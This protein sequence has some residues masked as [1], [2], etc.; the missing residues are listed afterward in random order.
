MATPFQ[1]FGTSATAPFTLKIHRG[2]GMVLLAMDWK[3]G[4][5]PDDFVGFAI[6]Y[7]PPGENQFFVLSNRLSF[8]D[9][10][11]LASGAVRPKRFQSTVSPIQKFRWVHFP[12]RPSRIGPFTY[13]VTPMSMQPDGHL[14]KGD[15]QTAAITLGDE[16]YPGQINIAFTRGFV[17]SQ[18]FV[19]RYLDRGSIATLVPDRA[20]DG[21]TFQPTH[22]DAA[23]AREW[24]G[25]EARTAILSVLDEAIA[26]RAAQVGV[27]AYDLNQPEMLTRLEALGPRL[28]III[29]DSNPHGDAHS[30]ETQAAARLAVSAGAGNVKRQHMGNLQHNKMIVV[31]GPAA[32]KAVGG[33]TNF[34]WRG[35]FIQSNNAVVVTGAAA[36]APF[37][38]AFEAY[39]SSQRTFRREPPTQIASLGLAGIDASVTFSPHR[40]D[41]ARLPQMA[42]EIN[43][44]QS[45]LFY[46]LAFLSQT[47]GAVTKAIE[48]ATQRSDLFIY[49]MSDKRKGI[50]LQRPDGNPEPVFAEALTGNVPEP[51]R[52]EPSGL[53]NNSV[54]T[55][56]HHKFLVVD[57]DTPDACVYTGSHNCS[58]PA[59]FDNGE[60]L[61]ILR[62]SRI[63]TSYMIE[64]L[65]IFDHYSF[66]IARK[67][68][69]DGGK[70]LTL[71]RPPRA[72][73]DLPWF[74]RDYTDPVRIRDREL[75]SR[76]SPV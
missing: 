7:E 65:R 13:R 55:R 46:S 28:R 60:N 38:A 50:V 33:S 45:S 40:D 54:G 42:A 25:F 6:E 16:T 66:R 15:A 63:A 76:V 11:N 19:D 18:A 57:F 4:R 62:D 30:A 10:A 5:P 72:P 3:T 67:K 39:W 1:V 27:V 41:T 17:S 37:Q 47:G 20:D 53:A 2:E 75:F 36:I 31:N 71:K 61:L 29:D 14:V 70:P 34:S 26:D 12:F 44:A 48:A 68:A 69:A 74:D 9:N 59:D 58:K 56:M 24:M 64:A 52:S 8:D 51:F 73:G 35:M 49:G 21:L 23:D 32:Q 22:P 43:G